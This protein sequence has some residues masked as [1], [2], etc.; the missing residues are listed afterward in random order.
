MIT[1]SF[2]WLDTKISMIDQQKKKKKKKI[3][4]VACTYL[5]MGK[6]SIYL[7]IYLLLFYVLNERVK[8][9]VKV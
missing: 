6:L 9:A 3:T 8:F 4:K 7:S 2:V 1:D 5:T